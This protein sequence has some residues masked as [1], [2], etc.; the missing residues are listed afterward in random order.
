MLMAQPDIKS[1]ARHLN[2][3]QPPRVW[4]LLVTIFGELA[5]DQNAE[6]SGQT[7]RDLLDV[8]GVR[9]EAMRVALHRLRNEG[10]IDSRKTGRRSDYFLTPLGLTESMAASPLIYS[11]TQAADQAWLVLTPPGEPRSKGVAVCAEGAISNTPPADELAFELNPDTNLPGWIST[12]ICEAP[13][14]AQ[15]QQLA[16]TIADLNAQHDTLRSM[17]TTEQ[18]ALRILLVHAWRRIILRAPQLPDFVF[19]E[20]WEG[21]ACRA[22]L[23]NLLEI[24]PKKDRVLMP[25]SESALGSVA[26]QRS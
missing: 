24:L 4:S 19:P 8:I 18:T 23:K 26:E 22:G 10:W 2:G 25:N 14:I 6:I 12:K 21:P 20:T 17:S 11:S 16:Q 7:L 5:Q 13:L 1:L 3:G 9:P 15:T